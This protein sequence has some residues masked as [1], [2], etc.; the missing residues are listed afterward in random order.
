MSSRLPVQESKG[1]LLLESEVNIR[2]FRDLRFL[3]KVRLLIDSSLCIIASA[4]PHMLG[5]TSSLSPKYRH[6]NS[7]RGLRVSRIA[8]SLE[9]NSPPS[10]SSPSPGSVASSP[11]YRI[12]A[13]RPPSSPRGENVGSAEAVSKSDSPAEPKRRSSPEKE[14]KVLRGRSV[15]SRGERRVFG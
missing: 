13:W 15:S 10:V 12:D 2:W 14:P 9:K 6:V 5:S 3:L 11:S 8:P 4:L 7:S 1:L